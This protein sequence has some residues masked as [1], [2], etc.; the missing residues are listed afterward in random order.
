MKVQIEDIRMGHAPD[1][2]T[3]SQGV[4]FRFDED[5]LMGHSDEVVDKIKASGGELPDDLAIMI[6]AVGCSQFVGGN[7]VLLKM[8]LCTG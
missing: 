3:C 1:T 8:G 6:A 4:T 7:C 5:Y 2:A